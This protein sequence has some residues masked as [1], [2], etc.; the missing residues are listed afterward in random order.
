VDSIARIY[1]HVNTKSRKYEYFLGGADMEVVGRIF[2]L[3]DE[4]GE[5]ASHFAQELNLSTGNVSDWKAGRAKPSLDVFVKI[6]NYFNVSSDYLLGREPRGT[7]NTISAPISGGGFVQGINTGSV[8]IRNGATS[9]DDG[10]SE[11]EIEMIRVMRTLNLK[12]R[13]EFMATA[14][15]FENL[16]E[17]TV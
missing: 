1:E 12:Q 9:K 14:W 5:T 17:V 4:R 13:H 15:K 2:A 11:D 7:H 3:L 10:L 6:V 16:D 8:S